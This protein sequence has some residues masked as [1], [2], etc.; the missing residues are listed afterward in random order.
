[1][2]VVAVN[3]TTKWLSVHTVLRHSLF[4]DCAWH[5]LVG[6]YQYSGTTYQSHLQMLSSARRMLGADGCAGDSVSYGWFSGNVKELVKLLKHIV[7][8]MTLQEPPGHGRGMK[9]QGRKGRHRDKGRKNEEMKEERKLPGHGWDEETKE[10]FTLS[11]FF[12]CDENVSCLGCEAVLF[13]SSF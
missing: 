11:S 8:T 2:L 13:A 10:E 5:R 4:L 3:K 12:L 7:Y 1:M 9:R 6:R